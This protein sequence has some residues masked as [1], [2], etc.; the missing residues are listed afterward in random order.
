MFTRR[1]EGGHNVE[2]VGERGKR[3]N[4]KKGS[5]TSLKIEKHAWRTRSPILS[6]VQVCGDADWMI[7]FP[8]DES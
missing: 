6:A 1:E 8:K 5:P 2:S 4:W 3:E 7:G